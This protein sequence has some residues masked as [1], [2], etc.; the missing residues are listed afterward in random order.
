MD[1]V[2]HPSKIERI[3]VSGHHVVGSY[4]QQGFI[5][6][7]KY[8]QKTKV[9]GF[10]LAVM[11]VLFPVEISIPILFTNV[12]CESLYLSGIKSG[13]LSDLDLID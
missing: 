2:W 9:L 10:H 13:F 4:L 12:L 7:E 11:L 6:F 3:S 8:K 1:H 5:K